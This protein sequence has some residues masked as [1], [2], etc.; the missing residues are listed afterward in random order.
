MGPIAERI[1]VPDLQPV[2]RTQFDP[3]ESAC[4][5]ARDKGLAAH[6][7]IVIEEDSITGVDPI[8]LA[9]VLR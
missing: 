2:L 1:E 8:G 7:R 3:S 5:L 4:D 9:V 6:W